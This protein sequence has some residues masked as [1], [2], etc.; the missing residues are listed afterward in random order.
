MWKKGPVSGDVM[1]EILRS[2]G[3]FGLFNFQFG[4]TPNP[5]LEGRILE[6]VGSYGRQIGRLADAIDVLIGEHANP[7]GRAPDR[8]V[9]GRH[10]YEVADPVVSGEP[11]EQGDADVDHALG[12]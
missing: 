6:D 5:A 1:Q 4:Q 3:Q 11:G 8:R 12:F 9:L 2:V 7:W 10:R